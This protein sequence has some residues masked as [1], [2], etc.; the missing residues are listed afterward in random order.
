MGSHDPWIASFE[1]DDELLESIEV[2]S[3]RKIYEGKH[4]WSVWRQAAHDFL[5]LLFK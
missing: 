4:V 3:I 5:P 1:N 2:K